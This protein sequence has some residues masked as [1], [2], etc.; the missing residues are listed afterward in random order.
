MLNRIALTL[1][2]TLSF[3]T[4]LTADLSVTVQ[5]APL[6]FFAGLVF[7]RVF[8]SRRVLSAVRSLWASDSLAFVLFLSL[9]LVG[10]SIQSPVDNSWEFALLLAASLVLARLYTAVVPVEE[11]LE[12]FFWSAV[13]SVVI[14]VPVSLAG[15]LEAVSTSA[16]F[17]PFSF[18]PNLL[19]F[20]FAGYFCAMVW[21][22]MLGDWRTKILS[23]VLGVICL[24]VIFFA[25]SRGSI[26]GIV[27]ASA[28]VAGIAIAR[29]ARDRRLPWPRIAIVAMVLLALGYRVQ[30]SPWVADSYDFVDRVLELSDSYRGVDTGLSGRFDKWRGTMSVFSDGTWLSGHGMRS[31]D[32][33]EQGID[34]SYLVLLYEVGLIPVLLIGVRF[35]G[36]VARFLMA[37]ARSRDHH[38]GSVE[39]ACSLLALA[40]VVNN[41]TARY[42]LSVGNPYSLLA[43]L[44]FVSPANH[45][46]GPSPEMMHTVSA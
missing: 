44:F 16:R 22:F 41:T 1:V 28:V 38:V 42:L 37:Y 34:N 24:A 18:H 11:V 27:S 17:S 43:L 25:S 32:S 9:L 45:R 21:K 39:L 2:F 13:V 23:G 7:C 36:V 29:R 6:V 40:F 26:L 12:A 30:S 8:F 19:G 20:V 35:A 46:S 5:A 15:F 3:L 31:S 14:F 33:I 10:A 4:Y